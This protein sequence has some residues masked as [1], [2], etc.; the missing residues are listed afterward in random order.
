MARI[1]IISNRVAIPRA[2]A[3]PGGLEVALCAPYRV[4]V[5]SAKLGL[6]EVNLGL[7]PGAGG[8]QRL[9]RVVGPEKA[10]EMVAFGAPVSAKDALAMGLVD[11]VVEEGRLLEGALA[12]ARKVV[13]ENR[14]AVPIRDRQDKVEPYRGR[15]VLGPEIF[16][17]IEDDW[18]DGL[19]EISL[20]ELAPAQPRDVVDDAVDQIMADEGWWTALTDPL[21]EQL[22][23]A[24]SREEALQILTRE[25]ELGDDQPMTEA[26]ARAGFALRIDALTDDTEEG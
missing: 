3:Q 2:G 18:D 19:T 7:L 26:L 21:L 14:K 6:P 17:D 22:R 1:F 10:M 13:A 4:A 15:I 25:A 11:E 8:T 24:N 12:F 16:E 5:P 23:K 9:P 20:A